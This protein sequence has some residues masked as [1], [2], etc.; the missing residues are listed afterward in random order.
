MHFV[1][2]FYVNLYALEYL[3]YFIVDIYLEGKKFKI[4]I[5][6]HQV[7]IYIANNALL[8]NYVIMYCR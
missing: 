8:L 2:L 4:G 7:F 5:E 6:S 3:I 1:D